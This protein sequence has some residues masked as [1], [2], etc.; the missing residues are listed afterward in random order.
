MNE[1]K[2]ESLFITVSAQ[3]L[4]LK[5][6]YSDPNGTPVFMVHGSIENGKIFY[7]DSGKGLAPF[8]AQAGFDVFV[9]DLRGRGKSRPKISRRNDHGLSHILKED[10]P[11]YLSKIKEIKGGVPQVWISHSWGAVML[12]AYFG[13]YTEN[14]NV[15]SMVFFGG[16]RR[17]ATISFKKFMDI[18]VMFNIISGIIVR[19]KGYLPLKEMKV[20]MDNESKGSYVE[21]KKWLNSPAWIDWNDG[22]DHSEALKKLDLP[23]T[24]SWIGGSDHVLGNPKDV[25]LFLAE[26][27]I[28]DHELRMIGK[29]NGN[30]HDYGHND[31]L[32]H[33]D[34][35]QDHFPMLVEWMKEPGPS[36]FLLSQEVLRV[37]LTHSS[38]NMPINL[39]P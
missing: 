32:T 30:L 4:H 12:L 34:A 6:I 22:F 20:G 26:A 35:V 28:G 5:R 15:S 11:A 16:K 31:I 27:G 8:L 33:K 19:L 17:I 29:A 37:R 36:G 25:K 18:N 39:Q 24:L 1:I 13:R 9:A 2:Q 38:T 10:M 23:P 3:E 7:S 21:T 14:C